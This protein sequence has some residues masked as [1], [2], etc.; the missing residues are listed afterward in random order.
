MGEKWTALNHSIR[1]KKFKSQNYYLTENKPKPRVECACEFGSR[2][3]MT[4]VAYDVV[5]MYLIMA[6]VVSRNFSDLAD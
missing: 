3:A 5:V 2:M 1:H 4:G 6:P